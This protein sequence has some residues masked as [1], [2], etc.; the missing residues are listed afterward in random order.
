MP[1]KEELAVAK[2]AALSP[3]MHG[4]ALVRL[5]GRALTLEIGHELDIVSARAG[6]AVR[7]RVF[8]GEVYQPERAQKSVRWRWFERLQPARDYLGERLTMLERDAQ[9]HERRFSVT[10]LH[11]S[12]M[13]W[14]PD[15]ESAIGAT[16]PGSLIGPLTDRMGESLNAAPAFT[17]PR[18]AQF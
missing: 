14:R 16:N 17:S 5:D 11:L 6:Y 1:T 8:I 13:A 2:A 9:D 7:E 15:P 4:Y 12:L 3:P 10:H 18:A